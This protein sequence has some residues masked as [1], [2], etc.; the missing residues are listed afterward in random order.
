MGNVDCFRFDLPG[1][2]AG[3]VRVVSGE[4]FIKL[5]GASTANTHDFDFGYSA[6]TEHHM[7]TSSHF[8]FHDDLLV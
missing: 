8:A 6:A 3:T 1:V 5:P 2:N 4:V 7:E